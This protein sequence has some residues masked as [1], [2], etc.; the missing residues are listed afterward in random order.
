MTRT[1]K[2]TLA[3]AIAAAAVAAVGWALGIV[4]I[5]I[6]GIATAALAGWF[7]AFIFTT[8]VWPRAALMA[9]LMAIFGAGFY[10]FNAFR[11]QAI[12]AAFSKM[13]ASPPPTAVAVAVA[14]K[15]SMP[16]Y[17]PGIGT[18]QAVHQVT[19]TSEVGGLVTKI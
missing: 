12:N 6:G 9:L 1:K 18:L 16:H 10:G 2:I 8:R 14:K 7:A 19:I 4:P 17:A 11:A 5:M 15:E 3:I 13:A